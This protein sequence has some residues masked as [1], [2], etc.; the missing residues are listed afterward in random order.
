M[1]GRLRVNLEPHLC[2]LG[3]RTPGW[4]LPGMH[5]SRHRGRIDNIMPA[6]KKAVSA[7]KKTADK[8][9]NSSGPEKKGNS[10][11]KTETKKGDEVDW[12]WGEGKGEGTVTE[13]HEQKVT[14]TI[15]GKQITRNGSADE[16][17]VLIQQDNGNK[18][19]KSGSEVTPV[20]KTRE[21][22]RTA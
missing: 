15:K 21:P 8:N 12:N 14:E 7:T 19:L 9:R 2:P 17:A 18:V 4:A 16:P 6:K 1:R 20:K 22:K 11:N 5:P 3:V 13:V 10:K